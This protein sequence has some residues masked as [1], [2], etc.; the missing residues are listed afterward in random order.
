MVPVQTVPTRAPGLPWLS[1]YTSACNRTLLASGSLTVEVNVGAASEV[2]SVAVEDPGG[3][4]SAECD[5]VG[6]DGAFGARS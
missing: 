6:V 2:N 3:V 5:T 4:Y 1:V